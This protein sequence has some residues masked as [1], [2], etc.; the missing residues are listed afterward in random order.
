M[1]LLPTAVLLSL[2]AG[3]ALAGPFTDIETALR[4][5]YGKYRV[6]LFATNMGNAAK[7][8]EAIAAFD[9]G[10]SER[11]RPDRRRPAI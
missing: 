7:S 5:V 9:K 3:T 4:G 6:A 1:R 11:V 10:W 8:A 2:L